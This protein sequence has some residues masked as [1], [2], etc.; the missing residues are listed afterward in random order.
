LADG[1]TEVTLDYPPRARLSGFGCLRVDRL[2][3]PVLAVDMG[4]L[5]DGTLV[6]LGCV[7]QLGAPLGLMILLSA[8]GRPACTRTLNR[9]LAHLTTPVT[10]VPARD[11]ARLVSAY[12]S[13]ELLE[14]E[15]ILPDSTCQLP[16]AAWQGTLG[17]VCWYIAAMV[18]FRLVQLAAAWPS[19]E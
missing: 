8:L 3:L 16:R 10:G 5:T 2:L 4:S 19:L 15:K 17:V 1:L 11:Q 9:Q 12:A 13:P 18:L 6:G 7:V 14:R